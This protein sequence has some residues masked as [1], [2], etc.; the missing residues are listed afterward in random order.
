MKI[1]HVLQH[2]G[3]NIG[4]ANHRAAFDASAVVA[5]RERSGYRDPSLTTGIVLKCVAGFT[6]EI[7]T[8]TPYDE[9][10]RLIGWEGPN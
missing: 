8:V 6:Y 1:V 7:E 2:P 3:D 4:K 9:V 10:L 5:V